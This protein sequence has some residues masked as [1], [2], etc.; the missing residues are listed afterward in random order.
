MGCRDKLVQVVKQR[1]RDSGF[2]GLRD[3]GVWGFWRVGFSFRVLGV[4]LHGLGHG[5]SWP[6]CS[7]NRATPR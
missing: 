2:L 1:F 4:R 6:G 3:L 5:V 7:T